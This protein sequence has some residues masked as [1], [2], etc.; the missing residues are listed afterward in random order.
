M[1]LI[2]Q[3]I[4]CKAFTVSM[5]TADYVAACDY[6]G[7]VSGNKE[8]DKF[9]KAGFHA[10]KSEFVDA[11]LIDELPKPSERPWRAFL[12]ASCLIHFGKQASPIH[13]LYFIK[14]QQSFCD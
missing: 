1:G 13:G 7:L 10:T 12:I 3:F 4:S 5:A 8:P 11:P 2:I 9:A 6:V 14:L